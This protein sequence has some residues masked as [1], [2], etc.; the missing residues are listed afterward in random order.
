MTVF[1]LKHSTFSIF[2]TVLNG[3]EINFRKIVQNEIRN[4]SNLGKNSS[5]HKIKK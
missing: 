4:T 2:Q 3:F 5:E 1:Q